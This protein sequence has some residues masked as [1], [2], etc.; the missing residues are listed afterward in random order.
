M[1]K[2]GVG[3]IIGSVIILTVIFTTVTSYSLF[4]ERE[5]QKVN[6]SQKIRLEKLKEKSNEDLA[7]TLKEE[8]DKLEVEITNQGSP[9]NNYSLLYINLIG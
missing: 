2:N 1:N 8:D 9:Y 4:I 7:I 5:N 6:D 3:A